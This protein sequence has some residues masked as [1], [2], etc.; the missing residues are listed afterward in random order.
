[1][2]NEIKSIIEY[3]CGDG[4]QLSL[5]RYP[6]YKGFDISSKAISICKKRFVNDETKSFALME[7]YNNEKAELSLSLDVIYHLVEDTIF[8][9]Y[10]DRLFDSSERFV[11]IFSSNTD[12]NPESQAPHVRHRKF[13]R[14]VE[15]NRR[16]WILQKR[17][18]NKYPWKADAQSGSF[19]DFY[20][21]KK[22]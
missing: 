6:V 20:I 22:I 1:M 9:D 18:V 21:Y 14:W 4:N 7:T 3:G 10:I 12:K 11:I 19:A 13:S 17:I 15:K 2:E 16:N 5:A 8:E